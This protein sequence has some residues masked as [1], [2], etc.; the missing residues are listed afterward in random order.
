[1]TPMVAVDLEALQ[2]LAESDR[3]ERDV[4]SLPLRAPPNGGPANAHRQGDQAEIGYAPK[5]AV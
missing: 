1:M 5:P 4:W 2:Y 3:P